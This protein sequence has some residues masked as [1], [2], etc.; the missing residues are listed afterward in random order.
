MPISQGCT[1]NVIQ[2]EIRTVRPCSAAFSE[3]RVIYA[4]PDLVTAV[5][6]SPNQPYP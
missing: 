2:P 5:P 4:V 3:S 1:V 6:F